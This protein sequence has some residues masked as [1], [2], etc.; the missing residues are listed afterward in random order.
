MFTDKVIIVTGAAGNVGHAVAR[1]LAERG[2]LVALV[3]H[4]K[5]PPTAV[6]RTLDSTRHAAFSGID[7]TDEATCTHLVADVAGKF[8]R[9][10]GVA[11]TV[12]GFAMAPLAEA[13][14]A[15]SGTGC[16]P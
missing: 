6:M 16:S 12:G 4:A 2:A 5:A 15:R 7:L 10:D 8:G 9:L 11:T 1:L 3:D 13:G 14:S